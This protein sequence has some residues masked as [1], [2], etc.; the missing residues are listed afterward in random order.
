MIQLHPNLVDEYCLE[1]T[2]CVLISLKMCHNSLEFCQEVIDNCAELLSVVKAQILKSAP[3]LMQSN[4][5]R[6][7]HASL[8]EFL[9][10]LFSKSTSVETV[11]RQECMKLWKGLVTQ[12]PLPGSSSNQLVGIKDWILSRYMPGKKQS[13]SKAP[14]L[15]W[16][17]TEINFDLDSASQKASTSKTSAQM[18][19]NSQ[20]HESRRARILDSQKN[21]DQFAAQLEFIQWL[22]KAGEFSLSDL[23]NSLKIDISIVSSNIQEFFRQ[24]IKPQ[25]AKLIR[26]R[27]PLRKMLIC[28]EEKEALIKSKIRALMQLYQF[29]NQL[30]SEELAILD[31]Y[32]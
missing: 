12:L 6:S 29:I 15:F 7:V 11:Y 9:D 30:S 31:A 14:L 21:H 16:S 20:R 3:V 27:N 19:C 32:R 1:I 17:I 4:T 18:A 13:R 23:Q 5:Q 25:F 2:R 8:P 22:T 10:F 26:D 24:V 28:E